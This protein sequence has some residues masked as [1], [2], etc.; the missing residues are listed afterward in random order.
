MTEFDKGFRQGLQ[1]AQLQRDIENLRSQIQLPAPN[2]EIKI[3]APT[4]PTPKPTPPA[5]PKNINDAFDQA[6]ANL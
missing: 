5:A 4:L 3:E 6:F 2:D 1:A